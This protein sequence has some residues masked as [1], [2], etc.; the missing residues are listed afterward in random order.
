MIYSKMC[1]EQLGETKHAMGTIYSCKVKM[2]PLNTLDMYESKIS[3]YY[4]TASLVFTL[5]NMFQLHFFNKH[6]LYIN[7][8]HDLHLTF[9]RNPF[10]SNHL[11]TLLCY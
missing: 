7:C 3:T 2:F 6:C 1:N 10:S 9:I 4:S 8:V 11:N 5:L